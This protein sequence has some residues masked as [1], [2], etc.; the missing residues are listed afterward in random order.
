MSL[1]FQKNDE[2]D[3]PKPNGQLPIESS[4]VIERPPNNVSK[5]IDKIHADRYDPD[6][7]PRSRQ[8]V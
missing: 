3:Q 4:L 2:I 8:V 5:N 1:T 7:R 6:A